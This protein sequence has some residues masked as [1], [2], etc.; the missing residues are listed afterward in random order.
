VAAFNLFKKDEKDWV[1][2]PPPDDS[3]FFFETVKNESEKFRAESIMARIM[4]KSK[5]IQTERLNKIFKSN[6]KNRK[7]DILLQ[8]TI[9]TAC[10]ST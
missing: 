7:I 10:R 2:L 4:L 8:M 5:L 6:N 1:T 9:I 3:I